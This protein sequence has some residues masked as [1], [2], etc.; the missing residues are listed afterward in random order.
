MY[1]TAQ[2]AG[3]G[4]QEIRMCVRFTSGPNVD[5]GLEFGQLENGL[6]ERVHAVQLSSMLR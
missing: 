2:A 3:G 4:G 5:A 6:G 1:I